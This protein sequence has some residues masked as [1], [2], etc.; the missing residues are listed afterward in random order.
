MKKSESIV[1]L[2]GALS[3]AQAEMPVVK[4]DKTNPFLKYKYATLGAVIEAARPVLAKHELSIVQFPVNDGF[5]KMGVTTI[6]THSSG[7]W[8][9]ETIVIPTSEQKGLSVAQSVGV[10]ISYLRRYSLASILGMYADE[11]VDSQ[12]NDGYEKPAKQLSKKP[13][14]D[15]KQAVPAD[16]VQQAR[17]DFGLAFAKAKEAGFTNAQLPKINGD[18]TTSQINVKLAEL[19]KMVAEK[20]DKQEE[21]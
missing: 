4:M 8:M 12:D 16:D 20:A 10:I 18:M 2:A 17:T 15:T 14:E 13:A 5:D 19:G 7:E 3:K 6:L 11:D 1:K 21:E 9:E